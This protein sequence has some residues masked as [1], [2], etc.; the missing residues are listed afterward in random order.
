M[1][2]EIQTYVHLS[3]LDLW[4]DVHVLPLDIENG[5]IFYCTY[6]STLIKRAESVLS[7]NSNIQASGDVLAACIKLHK[8]DNLRDAMESVISEIRQICK[9]E[10]CTVLRINEAEEKYSIV[11]T[12][13][14]PGSKLRRVTSFPDYYQIAAS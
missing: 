6:T 7:R 10:G 9:A 4:F 3:V 8:A 12:D 1:K 2:E 5:N 11:A 13:F 14:A